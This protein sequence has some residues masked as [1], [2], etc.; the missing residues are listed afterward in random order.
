MRGSTHVIT[1]DPSDRTDQKHFQCGESTDGEKR[2][3]DGGVCQNTAVHEEGGGWG[4]EALDRKPRGRTIRRPF[5]DNI[6]PPPS[7]QRSN[8]DGSGKDRNLSP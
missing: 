6:I 8:L 7:Q 5:L 4:G 1:N 2:L 3:A